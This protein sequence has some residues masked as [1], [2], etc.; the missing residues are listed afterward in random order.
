MW[1]QVEYDFTQQ[2]AQVYYFYTV[3]GNTQ[4]D[5]RMAAPRLTLAV[6]VLMLAMSMLTEGKESDG[7]QVNQGARERRKLV[8]QDCKAALISISIC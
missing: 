2:R 6:L 5:S 4:T 8:G 3:K 1:Q 7:S